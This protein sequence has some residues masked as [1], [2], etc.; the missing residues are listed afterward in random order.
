MAGGP[1]LRG[2]TGSTIPNRNDILAARRASAECAR[3]EPSAQATTITILLSAGT[4]P[5]ARN[6]DGATPLHLAVRT[7]GAAPV[8][9]LIEGRADVRLK[10]KGGLTP[11][12]LASRNSGW[13]GGSGSMAAKA[14]QE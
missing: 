9:T 8:R 12:S 6:N 10:N 13:S 4:E 3:L 2:R 7:R 5:N 11:V 1:E 14:Q